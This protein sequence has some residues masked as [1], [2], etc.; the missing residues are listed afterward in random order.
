MGYKGVPNKKEMRM[1]G[2][3]F[4]FDQIHLNENNDSFYQNLRAEV[5]EQNELFGSNFMNI[6]VFS[7]QCAPPPRASLQ[8]ILL[9]KWLLHSGQQKSQYFFLI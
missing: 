9:C 5:F 1:R 8:S 4:H 6:L 7:I 3:F 2:T